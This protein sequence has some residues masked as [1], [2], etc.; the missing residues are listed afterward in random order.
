MV[1]IW[2]DPAFL[3]GFWQGAFQLLSLT[4]VAAF[5]TLVYQGMRDRRVAREEL[6]EAIDEFTIS[7]YKPRKIYQLECADHALRASETARLRTNNLVHTERL[8]RCLE[9]LI[10]VTGRFRS[11]QVKLVPLYGYAEDLFA[12]YLAIWWYLKEIRTRMERVETL[13]FHHENAGSVDAF[14]RLID[15]FRYRIYTARFAFRPPRHHR[16]PQEVLGRMRSR[17]YQV[18]ERFF[19]QAPTTA[20]EGDPKAVSLVKP[21]DGGQLVAQD[22]ISIV[23]GN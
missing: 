5:G 15:E 6:I 3:S 11:L 1:T 19:G 8:R 23:L 10:E 13:Y 17:S 20:T 9:E 2:Q 4:I 16:P 12:H 18:Y 7:L 14:Y 21:G 22:W